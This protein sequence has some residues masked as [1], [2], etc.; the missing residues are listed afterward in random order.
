MRHQR[1]NSALVAGAWLAMTGLVAV[2]MATRAADH[3]WVLELPGHF[4]AH[5][6]LAAVL[7]TGVFFAIRAWR[8]GAAAVVVTAFL[9]APILSLWVPA[10]SQA[11]AAAHGLRIL[12][13]NVHT[14][15]RSH[16]AV[17]ELVMASDADIVGLQEVDGRW[18]GALQEVK[19]RYPHIV[20]RPRDDNFGIALLS[21][22]PLERTEVRSL[23]RESVPYVVTHLGFRG[24]PLTI[25]LAHPVPPARGSYVALR[26]RQLE[27][28]ARVRGEFSEREFVL[29][30]D[31]NTSPWSLAYR[32]LIEQTGLRNAAQGFGYRPTWP[33]QMPW[34]MIPI[35]HFLVSPGL[36]VLDHRV[37]TL[38]GSD[39]LPITIELGVSADRGRS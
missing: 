37:G 25:V 9:A 32:R 26:N 2:V 31:L 21:R 11:R 6:A 12:A 36:E 35:D 28:L 20:M 3:V 22:F 16:A 29:V 38:V 34:L 18:M 39:H 19:T 8:H 14:A 23:V 30:G 5:I 15:N 24:R 27:E 1:A 13:I 10:E 4:R 17:R 33:A 7:V